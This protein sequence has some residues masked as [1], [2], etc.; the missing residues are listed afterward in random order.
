MTRITLALL[1]MLFFFGHS[2]ARASDPVTETLHLADAMASLD[3]AESS[4]LILLPY[5]HEIDSVAR[6]FALSP[7]LIAAIVQEESRFEP[8]AARTERRYVL[9]KRVAAAA[10]LWC[11][12][13]RHTT[14]R[15][16]IF[17]RATSMG[18]MQPLGEI[19]R[20]QG[21]PAVFLSELFLPHNSLAQGAILLAKLIKRYHG[22]TLSAISAYNQGNN[23]KRRGVFENARYVYRVV[24]AWNAY[25]RIFHQ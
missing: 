6:R 21:F 17:F 9:S 10:R 11:E 20:E 23:R 13:H 15:T 2:V 8:Y 19:A 14:L 18:L 24:V 5:K 3:S 25:R 12:R 22:D 1:S 4:A 16:E 7:S